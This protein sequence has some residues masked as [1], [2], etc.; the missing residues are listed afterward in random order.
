[1]IVPM[2]SVSVVM[3]FSGRAD[4]LRQLDAPPPKPVVAIQRA[5]PQPNKAPI[6]LVA[7]LAISLLV[8]GVGVSFA[9]MA[10][11]P[12]PP[13]EVPAVVEPPVAVAPTPVTPEVVAPAP[14]RAPKAAPVAPAPP[15][16]AVAPKVVPTELTEENSAT[17]TMVSFPSG[18]P[19]TIDGAASCNTPCTARV[20]YGEHQ[21]V[22]KGHDG[23][24]VRRT[25]VVLEDTELSVKLSK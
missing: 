13:V 22:M 8:M 7:G 9:L 1:M 15:A 19:A 20:T 5:A 4:A 12:T 21:V 3:P 2:K 24:E 10:S 6:A 16:P 14:P 18:V 17:L 11:A 23:K 25:V